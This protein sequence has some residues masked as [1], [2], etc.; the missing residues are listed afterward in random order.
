MGR[1]FPVLFQVPT[2]LFL[3]L[4]IVVS[5]GRFAP[6]GS[7]RSLFAKCNLGTLLIWGFWWPVV[8]WITVLFGRVWCMVCPLE[9]VNT[10]S[11]RLARRLG[12][13]QRNLPRWLMGGG[14]ALVLYIVVQLLIAVAGLNRVPAYTA[15]LMVCLLS[16]A[17]PNRPPNPMVSTAD[18]GTITIEPFSLI[19]S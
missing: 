14:M 16:A 12:L 3:I 17:V 2:L 11:E 4:L 15:L 5:W 10:R 13:K 8:I 1:A 19:A 7:S 9:M 6:L 18:D